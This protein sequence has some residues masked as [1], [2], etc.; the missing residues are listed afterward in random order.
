MPL[1]HSKVTPVL[2]VSRKKE[3]EVLI[4]DGIVVKILAISGDRVKIGVTAPLAVSVLRGELL[5]KKKKQRKN[6]MERPTT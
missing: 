1:H 3:Q 2:V 4:G 5:S 6:G